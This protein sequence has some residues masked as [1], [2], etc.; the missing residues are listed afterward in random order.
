M[1]AIVLAAGYARRLSPLTDNCPKPLLPVRGV[2]L[3]DY[4]MAKVFAVPAVKAVTLVSNH[5]FIGHFENWL[6]WRRPPVP[7]RLL[8]D[9]TLSNETR[10]GGIG[11]LRFAVERHDIRG[12]ALVLAADNLFAAD[13][14]QMVAFSEARR[15]S[16]VIARRLDDLKAQQRT[17]IVVLDGDGR[18]VEFQEKP[19]V[20][21]SN[22]AVPPIYVYRQESLRRL[23]EYLDG[24][25]NPDAPGNLIAWLCARE[26]VFGWRCDGEIWDIGNLEQY[27]AAQERFDAAKE[28]AFGIR[29]W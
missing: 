23:T 22:L 6:R 25:N 12:D 19:Q 13:L 3:L 8:D 11:D 20:P 26:P 27:A 10:L 18:L 16:C 15:A 17:G 2:P 14:A 29:P 5:R 9:G 28:S 4:V 21:K 7:V 24:G 1:D